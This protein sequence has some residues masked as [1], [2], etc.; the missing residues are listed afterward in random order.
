MATGSPVGRVDAERHSQVAGDPIPVDVVGLDRDTGPATQRRRQR[1]G[2]GPVR[3][4]ELGQ[5]GPSVV[6][7]RYE[8]AADRLG[9]R[10]DERGDEFLPEAWDLPVEAVRGHLVEPVDGDVDGGAVELGARVELVGD[11]EVEVTLAPPRRVVL[12]PECA[13]A[14]PEQ[15]VLGEGEQVRGLASSLLPPRVEVPA[16]HHVCGN[17]LV[18]EGDQHAV[19]DHEVPPPRPCLEVAEALEDGGVVAEEGV[20]GVPVALDERVADEQVTGQFR[21]DLPETRRRGPRRAARRRASPARWRRPSRA[22]RTS[23]ARSTAA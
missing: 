15:E 10:A 19:V 18:V 1:G 21:V 17:P 16:R 3:R 20:L 4:V 6:G 7:R 23:V 14:V 12:H 9:Q 2:E 22:G 8:M 5:H 13:C 11:V